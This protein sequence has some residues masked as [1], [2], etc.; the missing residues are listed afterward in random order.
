MNTNLPKPRLFRFL[1]DTCRVCALVVLLALSGT[2][3]AQFYTAYPGSV[4]DWA[5]I[6][7]YTWVPTSDPITVGSY[8]QDTLY[9]WR[10]NQP[11]GRGS[12]GLVTAISWDSGYQQNAATVDFGRDYSV[13]IVFSELQAI[14]LVPVPEPASLF[15]AVPGFLLARAALR[16]RRRD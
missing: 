7:N 9:P 3:S 15:L 5:I 13:G 2:A 1:S 8:V 11:E 14:Q 16:R 12:I 4:E 6:N 10:W